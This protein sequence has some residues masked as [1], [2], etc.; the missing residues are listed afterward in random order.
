MKPNRNL[1]EKMT[2]EEKRSSLEARF[3]GNNKITDRNSKLY[4][5][6]EKI[7]RNINFNKK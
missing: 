4:K 7:C 5:E 1:N 6:I 2:K 3:W